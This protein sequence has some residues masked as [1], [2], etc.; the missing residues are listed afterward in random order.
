MWCCAHRS[1]L[2]VESI[3]NTVPELKILALA[4][5]F[6]T[7]QNKT[8]ML[9]SEYKDAK[10]FPRHNDVRFAQHQ[11][12]LIDVILSKIDGIKAIWS[13][14][15]Q[16]GDRKEK[17]KAGG[18]TNT[19][20]DRQIW[21][22]ALL[23]DILDVFQV[24]QKQFQRDDLLLCDIMTIRDGALRKIELMK[25]GPFPPEPKCFERK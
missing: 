13:K 22:T 18:F 11:V 6:R 12:Q 17:A 14:L 25:A 8:K 7:S 16:H 1:D 9:I 4:T 15:Q 10:Q 24:L 2:A 20:N 19:W 5:S 21:R 3:I 23:S